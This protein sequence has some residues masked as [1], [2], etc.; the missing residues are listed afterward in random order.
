MKNKLLVSGYVLFL[1]AIFTMV[2]CREDPPSLSVEV[3]PTQVDYKGSAILSWQGENLASLSINGTNQSK[4][5]FGSMPISDLL[6]TMT[7]D[8]VA[9]G[10]DGTTISRSVTVQVGKPIPKLTVVV[11]P[12]T[13]IPYK[14]SAIVSWQGE[15]LASLKVNGVNRSELVAWSIP[16]SNLIED[17]TFNFSAVG[18]DGSTLNQNVLV[19]VAKPTRTD[20]LCGNYWVMTEWKYFKDG[21]YRYVILGEDILAERR[22]FTKDGKATVVDSRNGKIIGDYQWSWIGQDSIKLGSIIHRY[23]LTNT[24]FIRSQ[25]NDSTITTF[26]GYPLS[27]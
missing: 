3:K 7:Y 17:T 1:L 5:N 16:L 15:N 26:K 6:E 20:T 21:G 25:E 13:V 24:T 12:N 14:G 4:L 11:T 2:G 8:F 19:N 9:I 10:L 27:P 18:L 23:E 22:Y